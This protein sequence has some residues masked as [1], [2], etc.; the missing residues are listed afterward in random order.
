MGYLNAWRRLPRELG[1]LLVALPAAIVGVTVVWV[2]IGLGLG[3]SVLWIGIPI[4]VG[5]LL[6]SRA[7]ASFGLQRLEWVG[8]GP[9]DRPDWTDRAGVPPTEKRTSLAHFRRRLADGR[10]WAA[11]VHAAVI[12]IVISAFTFG[13]AV[14]WVCLAI[15]GT[16]Y[17]FWV[18]FLPNRDLPSLTVTTVGSFGTYD[19]ALVATT[20]AGILALVTLP[21]ML[22]GLVLLHEVIARPM[23]GEWRSAVLRREIAASEASRESALLAEDSALRRLERDI[24]DGPQQALLRIQY[25]LSSADRRLDDD[26]AAKPLVDSALHLTQDT[27]RELREI[28]RGLAPPLLQDRGLVSAV[29]ALGARSVVPVTTTVTLDVAPEALVDVERSAYFIVSELLANVAK[30]AEATQATVSLRTQTTGPSRDLRID[31]TDDGKGGALDL[32]D[33]GL[34]GLRQRLAGLRGTL[35]I[36]SP[37]GGPTQV[38]V[39]IPLR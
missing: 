6:I 21:L 30:H 3:L 37:A 4:V 22:H 19:L 12:D 11:F 13:I 5:A 2:V 35:D 14:A 18:R 34:A 15:G 16:S 7:L 8:R 26:H 29:T 38:T 31:V 27:L 23:L 20:S 9:F 24:H 39:V 10:S 1:Y 25:D 36:T 32:P 17:A 33:H 28:S